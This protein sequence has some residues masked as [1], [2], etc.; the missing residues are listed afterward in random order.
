MSGVEVGEEGGGVVREI[1]GI[2][3]CV[4]A[5]ERSKGE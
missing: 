4:G 3:L 2:T 5:A 1:E